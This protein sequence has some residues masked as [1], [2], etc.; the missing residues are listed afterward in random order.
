M[1]GRLRRQIQ[2]GEKVVMFKRGVP[3]GFAAG[4]DCSLAGIDV[5]LAGGKITSTK[6]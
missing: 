3:G 4:G 5:S 6:Y 2:G 1:L